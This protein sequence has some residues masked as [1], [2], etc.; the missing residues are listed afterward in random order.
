MS[1]VTP[2]VPGSVLRYSNPTP[3]KHHNNNISS[4]PIAYSPVCTQEHMPPRISQNW[5]PWH[6]HVYS[7]IHL[8]ILLFTECLLCSSTTL[9]ADETK[10]GKNNPQV[11]PCSSSA[12]M[13]LNHSLGHWAKTLRILSVNHV[14]KEEKGIVSIL[15]QR[16]REVLSVKFQEKREQGKESGACTVLGGR[17]LIY[18]LFL[19]V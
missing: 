5:A 6:T 12:V 18:M 14:E 9:D 4:T 2:S 11:S 15:S 8:F 7:L 16:K 17:E 13:T 10:I 1:S 19:C 3:S